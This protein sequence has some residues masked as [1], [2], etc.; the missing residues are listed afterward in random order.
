MS[1]KESKWYLRDK[2]GNYIQYEGE[3]VYFE[4]I[5]EAQFFLNQ[6]EL[7]DKEDR[8]SI[9]ITLEKPEWYDFPEYGEIEAKESLILNYEE[10]VRTANTLARVMKKFEELRGK[11]K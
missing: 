9:M 7:I 11:E 6:D 5:A 8:D 2:D 1:I 4:N 10:A 3:V